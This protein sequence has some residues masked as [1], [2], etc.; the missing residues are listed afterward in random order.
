MKPSD[1]G[2]I[3]YS[4]R[5]GRGAPD[6]KVKSDHW[7]ARSIGAGANIYLTLATTLRAGTFGINANEQLS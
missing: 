1:N 7:E 6:C 3:P 2:M 5:E 4:S